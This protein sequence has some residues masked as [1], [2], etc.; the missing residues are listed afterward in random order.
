M[1]EKSD[2]RNQGFIVNNNYNPEF[3]N[4]IINTLEYYNIASRVENTLVLNKSF[5]DIK[6]D[7]HV[8]FIKK[9]IYK[10]TETIEKDIHQHLEQ[11]VNNDLIECYILKAIKPQPVNKDS[12]Y[13][14]VLNKFLGKT[15]I[16]KDVFDK[17]MK[18]LYDLDYYEIKENFIV[19]VP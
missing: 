5:F 14:I 16:D 7:I 4:D 15:L 17:C 19:Y 9:V 10:E 12:L 18:R 8:E 2:R 6:Q 13:D 11:V 1:A 3:I